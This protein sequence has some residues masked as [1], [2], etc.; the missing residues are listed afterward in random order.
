MNPDQYLESKTKE[1]LAAV[2]IHQEDGSNKPKQFSSYE[3][4]KRTKWTNTI[5]D[6]TNNGT[7][8]IQWKHS[9]QLTQVEKLNIIWDTLQDIKAAIY[10]LSAICKAVLAILPKPTQDLYNAELLMYHSP[11]LIKLEKAEN[12]TN[13]LDYIDHWTRSPDPHDKRVLPLAEGFLN[14]K[15]HPQ[16][17]EDNSRNNMNRH[18]SPERVFFEK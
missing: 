2:S 5:R 1:L 13:V 9:D 11:F 4:L 8:R 6:P 7:G 12:I 15:P 16:N 17:L 18:N 14:L 10:R 3:A